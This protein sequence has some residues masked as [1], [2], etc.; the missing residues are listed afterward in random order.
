M[1]VLVIIIPALAA[2]VL[3]ALWASRSRSS[4]RKDR[5]G[6]GALFFGLAEGSWDNDGDGDGGECS[7]G[8]ADSSGGDSGGGDCGG[9]DGG[10]GGNG[11]GD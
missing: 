6:D 11:G 9:G 2:A 5:N 3:L 4:R 10:G 1:N 8:D 7:G